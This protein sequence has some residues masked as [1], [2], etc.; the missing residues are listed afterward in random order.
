M[1]P[2]DPRSIRLELMARGLAEDDLPAEPL[3]LLDQWLGMATELGLHNAN[4][5]AVATADASGL[6]SVRNVLLRG[7]PVDGLIF[8]TNYESAKGL[9]LAAN[10]FA[11]ALFTWLPLER[12]IRVRGPITKVRA[13]Q[14]DAYFAS[15]DRGSRLS[16]IASAQSQPVASRDELRRRHAEL[17]E[18]F[19]GTEPPRP[20]HWGGFHLAAERVEFW[21]GRD[22]RL[23]DRLVY[24]RRGDSW[25]IQRLQP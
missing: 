19:D 7:R 6:P 17:T 9:Q 16:A 13:E 23:H 5:M 1:E 21:Q 14:S 2:L 22:F 10:P 15:R 20:A 3:D 25:E 8:Y 12:Q 18:R 11:E 24:T 4:A